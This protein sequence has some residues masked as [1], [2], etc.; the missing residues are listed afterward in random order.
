MISGMNRDNKD[1]RPPEEA[2]CLFNVPKK[3]TT[4][5]NLTMPKSAEVPSTRQIAEAIRDLRLLIYPPPSII[6]RQIKFNVAM[7]ERMALAR[8]ATRGMTRKSGVL[9]TFPLDNLITEVHRLLGPT[10]ALPPYNILL[11]SYLKEPSPRLAKE[12]LDFLVQKG[13]LDIP[14]PGF[15]R[16]IFKAYIRHIHPHIPF[17]DLDLFSNAIFDD[18]RG[19]NG[20][21]SLLLFQAVMF[22]GAIFVDLKFLYAAGYL[23]RRQALETLFQRV[24]VSKV[25]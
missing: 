19:G 6:T 3:M 23:S 4:P 14:H 21:I 25:T 24:Q 12:D 2:L 10:W 18:G 11:P 13:A 17:L 20:S 9:S 8:R 22:A 7:K 1:Y 16:D 15:T 5:H